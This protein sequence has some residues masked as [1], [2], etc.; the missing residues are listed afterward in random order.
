MNAHAG[1]ARSAIL[2]AFAILVA[3]GCSMAR[4]VAGPSSTARSLPTAP[5]AVHAQSVDGCVPV[6]PRQVEQV[7]DPGGGTLTL[8][9]LGTGP[10]VVILSEQSNEVLCSWLPFARQLAASG[11]RV[12]LWDFGGG[13]PADELTAV[14]RHVA[15][16]ETTRIVLM[17]ASEG[18]KASLVTA[19]RLGSA[20]SGAVSLSAEAI[21][22]PGIQVADSVRRLHCPLLLLTASQDAYDSAP[23]ARQ[24]MA[25]APSTVKRLV[26][27]PGSDHG[28]A[29]LSG[30]SGATT[31]PAVIDFL[32]LVL[33]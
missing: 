27:V 6:S 17:G 15:S 30:R 32:R 4:T 18:A 9:V 16:K 19:A 12:V 1:T 14:A 23:A 13:P 25:L 28:T 2:L 3:A 24:F 8:A 11:Y 20:V 33:G 22:T 26:T 10:R 7:A 31:V 21:L 29:L 5:T